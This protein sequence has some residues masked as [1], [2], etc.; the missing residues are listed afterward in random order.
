MKLEEAIAEFVRQAKEPM[1]LEAGQAPL[2]LKEGTYR[3]LPRN[4][5][6]LLEAWDTTR[7]LVRRVKGVREATRGRL[8]LVTEHFGKRTGSLVLYDGARPAEQTVAQRGKRLVFREVMRRF[9]QRQFPGWRIAELSSEPDLEHSLSAV[10]PRAL[11]E[12]GGSGWAAIAAGEGT[13][14]GGLLTFGLIWLDYVRRREPSL[15]VEGL[16]VFVP[17]GQ[18]KVT[19]LRVRRLNPHVARVLLFMHAE[20]A[21]YAVD[22]GDYG[23]IETGLAV[24]YSQMPVSKRLAGVAGVESVARAD[25]GISY[26]VRGLE[27]ARMEGGEW[28]YGIDS[29]R[30]LQ[31]EGQWGE[32]EALAAAVARLRSPDAADRGNPLYTRAPESWMESVVRRQLDVVDAS[33]VTDPVYG[34]VPAFAGGERGVIDL[35]AV[36]GTGRLAVVELKASMDIQLAM[37]AL[38]YWLRVAWHAERGEF[39]ACGYF[40]GME[41]RR[42]PPRLLLVAPALEFHPTT[43]VVLRYFAPE[44]EVERVGVGAG[45]Q[46]DLRVMFRLRGAK[47]AAA[48][49]G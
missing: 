33:L 3:L 29:K 36:D 27:I 34:Q 13:D 10:Y 47:A 41:L 40:P 43:G 46:R 26:R 8:T 25:G 31:T 28:Y 39:G 30:R 15:R 38:D 18:E 2:A 23:N 19:C 12:K 11:V 17:S 21:E 37:Q 4:N 5:T 14:A 20:G 1:V 49:G 22:P 48:L 9:V 24:R 44:I 6:V 42:D 35:L 32:V 7:T 16:A 45:W